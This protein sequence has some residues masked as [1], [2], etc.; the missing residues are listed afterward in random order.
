MN[1]YVDFMKKYKANPS[2]ATLLA[3]YGQIIQQYSEFSERADSVKG[4]LS[5][6]DLSEYLNA[7]SRISQKLAE[8]Q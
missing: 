6:D 3:D 4:E 5:G 8:V 7:L 2:D 1:K